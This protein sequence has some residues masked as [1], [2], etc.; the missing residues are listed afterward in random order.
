MKTFLLL[1]LFVTQT[2]GD[3]AYD[4]LALGIPARA[5]KIIDRTG[6]ALGYIELHEHPAWVIYKLTGGEVQNKVAKRPDNFRADP[7]IPIGS[8]TPEGYRK[9]GYS[10]NAKRTIVLR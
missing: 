3:G 9:S 8:A 2:S 1:L 5:D 4:N 6:Y 7:E 10:N